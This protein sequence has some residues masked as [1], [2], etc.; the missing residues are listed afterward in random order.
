MN[1]IFERV[2][3][4]TKFGIRLQGM[5][6]NIS[7]INEPDWSKNMAATDQCIFATGQGLEMI[8][9]NSHTL[10]PVITKLGG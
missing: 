9:R 8:G 7:T 1:R 4:N 6:R 3:I 5:K 10:C 2:T